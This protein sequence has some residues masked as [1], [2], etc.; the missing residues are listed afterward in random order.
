MLDQM[1][2]LGLRRP[3]TSALLDLTALHEP[4]NPE[5]LAEALARAVGKNALFSRA[6]CVVRTA[7][8]KNFAAL[9]RQMSTRP[10]D[11]AIFESEEEGLKWLGVDPAKPRR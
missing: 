4:P 6:A 8:Q 10:D 1:V 9:L 7:E 2:N 3:I 11:T 5:L